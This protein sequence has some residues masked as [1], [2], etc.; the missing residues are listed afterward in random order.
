MRPIG[1]RLEN[2]GSY[3]G[4]AAELDFAPLELFAISGPTGAGKSTLL[5]AIIFALYGA[6][7]RLGPHPAGAISLGADRMSVVLDFQ[8]GTQR[9][10]VT[11]VARRRGAGAAQL[12]Q[13]GLDDHLQPLNEGVREVNE[14]V[15]RLVGLSYDAF[16]QAVV[17]PQGEFQT[18]LKNEPRKRVDILSKILRLEIYERM[19]RLASTKSE[20]LGQAVQERE[21]RLR[22]DYAEAT[23][24]AL[25]QLTERECQLG[26]QIKALSVRVGEAEARRDSLRVAR[27]KTRALEQIRSRLGQLQAHEPQIRL[28]E[29]QL[30]AARRAIPVIPLIS[31]ARSAEENSARAKQEHDA[32]VKHHAGLEREYKEAKRQL[33]QAE[34]ESTEI[35]ILE[36]H[37]AALD[38]AIGRM[39]PRAALLLE[40]TQT[41]KQ[42]RH[43]EGELN[44]A[45]AVHQNAENDLATARLNLHNADHAI[46]AVKFDRTL[47][48]T[49]DEIREEAG[50]IG[51]LRDTVT[52]S[53]TNIQASKGRLRGREE[54]FAR[55]EA[56]AKAAERKWE[57]AFQQMQNVNQ[58]LADASHKDAVA[59]LRKELR[60]GEPC[61]VC[62]HSVASHPPP[63]PTPALDNLRETL[64][65]AKSTEDKAREL[66][67]KVK[68]VTADAGVVVVAER[69]N[70]EQ[71]ITRCGAAETELA[72][73]CQSLKERVG[74]VVSVSEERNIEEQVREIYQLVST[75]KRQH[76]AARHEREKAEQSVRR[77]EQDCERLKGAISIGAAQY[78]Q[79]GNKIAE[80]QRQITEIDEEVRKVTQTPQ[81]QVEREL[82]SRRRSQLASAL[83]AS[84]RGMTKASGELRAAAAR[85]D[86]SEQT[87]KRAK[88]DA[89]R[90]REEAREAAIAAG[91]D[92]EATAAGAAMTRTD[93]ERI[94][95]Q[96]EA[97]RDECRTVEARI[98]ELTRELGGVEVAQE[99]LTAA[100]TSATQLRTEIG[101]AERSETEL[102]T[103]IEML[104]K[105]IERGRELRADL[106]QQR[107]QHL[108]YRN[109]ALDLRS[110]RFQAFL[111]Q[112]TFRELVSGASVRLWDLTK[113]YRFEWQDEAFYVVDY[114]NARQ[115]RSAD[116][117]SGGETFLASLA[118][119]LQLS[120]Q[121]QRA[122]GATKLDSL[123][124]D[125]GFGTLDPEALDAAASAIESLRV[126]GRMVGI[127]SHIEEL[128]L[129]LPA[130]VRVGKTPDGSRLVLEAS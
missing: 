79:H 77:L 27:E 109:L 83:Q 60:I 72:A 99:T 48:D 110:D 101:A 33:T 92:D 18:F 25:R 104:T 29:R 95:K 75:A 41:E 125:E 106:D 11:R 102:K 61:P 16:V 3:R 23:P 123:F 127:I 10:R 21:R 26:A 34:Q 43:A 93:D 7:P 47:F 67:D 74:A 66:M 88:A 50:R 103:R 68:A 76:E 19:R 96:V 81:P 70:V 9:Y 40:Q 8:M 90:A 82:L 111:L 32:L 5:D 42:M 86:A 59:I 4:P 52:T 115:L 108:L 107:A 28:Y 51:G 24:E 91:F 80:L 84:E 117:L 37:I 122:A 38:Q 89:Q 69:H 31:T 45:R 17:L 113:R 2:F 58:E 112:Q 129:R 98:K 20:M 36:E 121:V 126:G 56:A 119:A 114:D 120:E 100:E 46:S 65:Q 105:A 78:K 22:E 124:I 14:A 55:T 12:E 39:R 53:A 85:L 57:R 64:E 73:A 116:T 63:I 54:E 1:L 128:S 94:Y 13:L 118:L 35:P 87:F 97:H 130:R 71:A 6:T 15:A 49:L 44:N 30:K 62:E